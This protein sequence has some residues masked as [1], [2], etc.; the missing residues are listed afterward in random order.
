M[1]RRQFVSWAL[2]SSGV[3]SFFSLPNNFHKSSFFPSILPSEFKKNNNPDNDHFFI[4]VLIQGGLDP[5]YFFDSRPLEMTQQQLQVN[6]NTQESSLWLGT[7]GNS[8]LAA[9]AT[10]FL[11]PYRSYFSVINGVLMADNFDGH[12]QNMNFYLSGSPFGGEYFGTYLNKFSQFPLDGVINGALL[13]QLSNLDKTVPLDS[14]SGKKLIRELKQL[15]GASSSA[16]FNN[17]LSERMSLSG[18]GKGR[19]SVGSK[20]MEIGFKQLPLIN[21]LLASIDLPEDPPQ[22]N[23]AVNGEEQFLQMIQHLF[24]VKLIHNVM[25]V[26]NTDSFNVDTHDSAST[27]K[28]PALAQTVGEKLARLFNFLTTQPYDTH[29]SLW[30]VSTLMIGSEFGRT[31][32]QNYNSFADS[33][34][35]HNPLNNSILIGGKGIQ[36]GL[37]IGN[38]DYTSSKER[39]SLAHLSL[40][41]L[42]IKS[43][44][45]PFDFTASQSIKELHSEYKPQDY[46]NIASVINTIYKAFQI[47]DSQFRP[48]GRNLPSAPVIAAL[49]K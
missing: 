41:P 49:L 9:P 6:Y 38:S 28:T 45:R 19:F 30:D 21:Y 7:N 46:L 43:M 2:Q 10:S 39:L 22:D 23:N 48:I 3:W 35:D 17:Y 14:H 34:T 5:L 33:G 26:L 47:P 44:G 15:N 37:V 32:R 20:K 29:R 18:K 27:Q 16:E 42:K 36:S 25:I 24:Q 8:T 4:Q 1:N 12:D 40:D 13:A 11:L 31:M